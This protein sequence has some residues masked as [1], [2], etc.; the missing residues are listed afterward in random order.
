[1][2]RRKNQKSF[3][4]VIVPSFRQEK[5]IG[6]DL[7]N[8][9]SVLKKI[10]YDYELICVVDGTLDGTF[11]RAKKVKSK[12]L[13]VIGYKKNHGKGYAIRYGMRKA[14]GNL[15][16]FIDAG[17]DLDPNGLSMLLEHFEWYDADIIVGSKRHPV[18]KI[19]Y[20]WQRRVLSFGYQLLIKVLF[21]LKIRDSQVGMKFFRKK[22]LQD[23]LPRLMVKKYAFDIEMLAV[24]HR[25]GYRRIFEAPINLEWTEGYSI[26]TKSLWRNIYQ[27]L[28]D[29]A[30]IFYRLKILHYYDKKD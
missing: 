17:M 8:I 21:G 26:L 3:L 2:G 9:E 19:N 5:T 12:K 29:T 6:R 11:E 18:S 16:A 30:A 13:K 7:R 1:M 22:V 27:M 25:L 24:A 23:V 14:K 10:R 4:S 15:I 20:P 28:V